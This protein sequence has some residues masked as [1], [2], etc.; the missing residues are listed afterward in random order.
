MKSEEFKTIRRKFDKTQ[1]QMARLLGV[2]VKAVH[3]YEQGW[4]N[5][6]GHIERQMIFLISRLN[7]NPTQPCWVINECAEEKKT[8]CPA[9]EFDSGRYCWLVNGTICHGEARSNWEEKIEMCKRCKV[10]EDLL[11]SWEKPE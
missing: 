1:E 7:K 3:S 9:W 4:R 2:S 8:R 6:P 5:I 10:F 11:Q